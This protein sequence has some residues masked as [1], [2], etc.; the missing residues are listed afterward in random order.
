MVTANP[1]DAYI[2]RNTYDLRGRKLSAADS[3]MGLW[4]YSYDAFGALYQQT[5]AKSQTST[6]GYDPLGRL[7]ARTEPDM[8]S[9]W[10]YGT[11]A[12]AHNID[13][14][15]SASCTS[16]ASGNAC[17]PGYIRSYAYDSLG[18]QS[19]LTLS[20]GGIN[21]HSISTYDPITGQLA[22]ARNYSGFTLNYSYTPRGYLST[23]TDAASG[24]VYWTANARNAALQLTRA[25]AGNGVVTAD[26]FDPLTGRMV[27]ICATPNIG[28]CDGAI[29]NI[30][31]QYD[32]VGNLLI[33][34]D[35]L[36]S[37]TE[38]FTFD[39]L[40]RLGTYSILTGSGGSTR[41]MR[42]NSAGSITEK[43]DI[44][45]VNGCFAYGATQPHALSSIAGV[46]NGVVNPH[47]FYDQNGNISCVTAL[48]Q[49]DG[50]AAKTVTW[51]S[52][53]MVAQVVQGA[54]TVGLVYDEGH[55]RLQQTAPEG[56]TQYLNDP[57][58][59]VMT[60]RFAP[61]GG[62]LYWR[63][64]IQADGHIVAERSVKGS[65]V[66][67]RYFTVDHLGSTIAL[68]DEHG[69]LAESDA[70]DAWGRARDATTG[71]DDPT[72]S[73]PGQSFT[74]R[75]FSGHEEM[76]DLCLVNMNA[77]IYD[78]AIGRFM[79]P[80]DIIPDAFNGQSYNRYS[81]VDNNP[82]SYTDPTGHA[83]VGNDSSAMANMSSVHIYIDTDS[84][85][86]IFV[87]GA[88]AHDD[89]VAHDVGLQLQQGGPSGSHIG[90]AFN[91]TKFVGAFTFHG[92]DGRSGPADFQKALAKYFDQ[93][94]TSG[95]GKF[96]SQGSGS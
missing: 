63:S 65:T 84:E 66:T 23:I 52:F 8:V 75:G 59:G 78:P 33:R 38:T 35:T 57:A 14:L 16:G 25:T 29:A 76:A 89:Q 5:D 45:A 60:E 86:K 9:A 50:S 15:L 72:C 11:S 91:G 32:P 68:T 41:T 74:T 47:F 43:S 1:P 21:Y 82:L 20:T 95:S 39:S 94:S 42:Y 6:M 55:S 26:S 96:S 2:L 85:G 88:G 24:L 54:T 34:S 73:K 18:R 36:H 3:D 51:T 56:V 49:C 10:A 61:T 28:A 12:A 71:A 40:N 4:H 80:D 81:Y 83:Q 69:A 7:V 77:R 90:L 87:Q 79:S 58:N 22:S 67:V 37:V 93:H 70:Y 53:N 44:C 17:G 30:S 92:G 19:Q 31:N 46:Y 13:Q 27:N 48:A 62:G 64:Y